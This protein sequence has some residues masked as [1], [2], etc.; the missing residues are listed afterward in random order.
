MAP[1][2]KL[3]GALASG[4]CHSYFSNHLLAGH[5]VKASFKRAS[6]TMPSG[7]SFRLWRNGSMEPVI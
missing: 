7:T 4:F 1:F 6:A 2:Q 5:P 3:H